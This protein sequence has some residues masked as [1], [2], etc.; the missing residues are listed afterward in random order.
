L[1]STQLDPPFVDSQTPKY[2]PP[3]GGVVRRMPP[4]PRMFVAYRWF[5]FAASTEILL[6]DVPTNDGPIWVQVDPPSPER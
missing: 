6:I 1:R 2:W 5:G 3:D 4:R